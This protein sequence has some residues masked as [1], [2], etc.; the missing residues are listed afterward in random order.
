MPPGDPTPRRTISVVVA[1]YDEAESLPELMK[2]L[3]AAVTDLVRRG[4]AAEVILVD[5]GS[6]DGSAVRLREFTGTRPHLRVLRLARNFGQTA[7]LQAGFLAARGEV[8]VPLDA[9]LQNDPADIPRLIEQLDQ[10]YDVVSG[11]RK[12]RKD[13][14]LNRRFPSWIANALISLVS[15]VRLHDFGCTLKAYRRDAL[16]GVRLYGEMHRLLPIY[17]AQRGA[18]VAELVVNH[19]PRRHGRS[20]Y[21][22]GRIPN[23]ILDLLLVQFFW[24]YGTKPL[25]VFGKFGLFNLLCSVLCF[26]LMVWFKYWGGKTFVETP[27]PLVVVMFFLI[28]SLSILMGVL[29][30]VTM[31]TYHEAS[32]VPTYLVREVFRDGHSEPP[33]ELL[34][35]LDERRLGRGRA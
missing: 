28:G 18:R 12:Q 23:V 31:R 11:W 7:A 4:F 2:A 34:R 27:L 15:G 21:G 29:A 5:D 25:H 33:A 3:D 26:G 10:G 6:N 8:V 32:N 22:L 14:A 16:A 24:K 35:E 13:G 17:A 19:R 20:K 9:D 1:C 30:E